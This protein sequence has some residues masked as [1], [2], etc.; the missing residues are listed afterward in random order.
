MFKNP[1][2]RRSSTAL[3]T[4]IKIPELSFGAKR[5]S[6]PEEARKV[7]GECQSYKNQNLIFRFRKKCDSNYSFKFPKHSRR[8][9][10]WTPPVGVIRIEHFP[11]PRCRVAS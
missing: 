11:Y 7:V 10:S 4:T 2:Q 6:L 9:K 5:G 8:D 3:P 1:V